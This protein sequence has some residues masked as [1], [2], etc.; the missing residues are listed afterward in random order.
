MK[1]WSQLLGGLAVP[2]STKNPGAREFEIIKSNK[3]AQY[4]VTRVASL[5]IW[6]KVIA[7]HPSV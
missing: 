4:A 3:L 1:A 6:V 2:E 7:V 5:I